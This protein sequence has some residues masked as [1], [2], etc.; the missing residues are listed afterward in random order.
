MIRRPPRSTLFPYTT[1]FRSP[2]VAAGHTCVSFRPSN[3]GL[4]QQL[5]VFLRPGH[6]LARSCDDAPAC[7]RSRQARSGRG[8]LV[9]PSR[10][11]IQL[12]SAASLLCSG[13]NPPSELRRN[14]EATFEQFR[15]WNA[16]GLRAGVSAFLPLLCGRR[17]DG[18]RR[19]KRPGAVAAG[20]D[21]AGSA[22]CKCA[23]TVGASGC[24]PISGGA[25]GSACL[26]DSANAP[27]TAPVASSA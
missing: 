6:D 17:I 7:Q 20:C 25:G 9:C 24:K 13:G 8:V 5:L 19:G 26:P 27:S 14:A 21:G 2:T 16:K 4:A 10:I 12:K 22:G 23:R 3:Q 11:S 18:R 15:G 1:L